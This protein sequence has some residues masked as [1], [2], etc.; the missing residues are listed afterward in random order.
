MIRAVL[1]LLLVTLARGAAAHAPSDAYLTLELDGAAVTGRLEV[2]LR[3]LDAALAI[4]ADGDRAVTWGEVLAREAGITAWALGGI[5]L[6]DEA[7]ACALR[8]GALLVDRH[9]DGA[10]AVVPFTASCGGDGAAL[11][12]TY[13]L[14]AALDPLHRG[15]VRVTAGGE[16][17]TA[18]LGPQLP[19]LELAGAATPGRLARLVGFVRDG[20]RH[21][22]LGY[23]H[24]LFLVAL[25]LPAVVRREHGRWRPVDGTGEACWTVLAVV[26]AFTLAHSLTLGLAVLHLVVLPTALVESLVALSIVTAAADNLVPFVRRRLLLAFGFGLVHGLGFAGALDALGLEGGALVT[27]LLAFNLGVELGQLAI[28]ALLLPALLILRASPAYRPLL[29]RAGSAAIGLAGALW[30][31]ERLPDAVRTGSPW[32]VASAERLVGV[33]VP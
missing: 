9:A 27:A 21:I 23:D 29:L 25:L 15:L 26:S 30:L 33:L 17:R 28:V 6:E 7:G 12:L 5:T 32:L 2:A 13:R 11:K 19:V 1:V 31:A 4:D 3:D 20:V 10:Y 24:L 16:V 8:P 18:V 14:L 22:L